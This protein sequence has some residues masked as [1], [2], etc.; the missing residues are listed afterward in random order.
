MH[1]FM[2]QLDGGMKCPDIWP[3]TILNVSVRM[4]Q[5][6]INIWIGRLSRADCPPKIGGPHPRLKRTKRL[7]VLQVRGNSSCLTV[8]ELGRGE[9]SFT[10][11]SHKSIPRL[12]VGK[13]N[14]IIIDLD[15]W[16][17]TFKITWG[18]SY[19]IPSNLCRPAEVE[20]GSL[21]WVWVA[22]S[23]LLPKNEFGRGEKVTETWKILCWPGDQG[24]HQR[25]VMSRACTP[26]D[27]MRRV[28]HLWS[29]LPK[30]N[31]GLTRRKA[32]EHHKF[33]GIL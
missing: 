10:E 33:K 19:R 30:N 27:V 5:H 13:E 6:E 29:F 4:L 21:L 9:K 7:T 14:G 26:N 31:P 16:F 32:A 17:S 22:L 18:L 12:L 20:L 28:L 2:C 3:D 25:C 8:F 1:N 24:E 15:R 23:D 11:S